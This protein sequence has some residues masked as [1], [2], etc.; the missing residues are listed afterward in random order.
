M[1]SSVIWYISI[2][3]ES[4]LPLC[5]SLSITVSQSFPLSFSFPLPLS[6][7]LYPYLFLSVCLS[8]SLSVYFSPS[9][10][11]SLPFSL[12]HTEFFHIQYVEVHE[13]AAQK[14]LESVQN[15]FCH[16]VAVALSGYLLGEVGVNICEKPGMGGYD[17]FTALH[18]HF[19]KCGVKTQA[20]LLTSYAKLL[21]L[22]PETKDV[23]SDVFRKYSV[24]RLVLL[25]LYERYF[26]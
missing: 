9:L 8:Q 21:N 25:Y 22:Y 24:S 11:F 5:P 18:Q 1:W 2:V 20:I 13:Y 12:T 23:I 10:S 19:G 7:S 4:R 26:F 14:M 15:K 6:I 16:E 17:Q 3:L